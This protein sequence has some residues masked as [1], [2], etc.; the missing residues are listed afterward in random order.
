MQTEERFMAPRGWRLHHVAETSST[1]DLAR[2]SGKE[3]APERTLFVADHQTSG[4]G[5]L[6]RGWLEP[7]GGS[8]LFSILFR[9]HPSQSFLLTM[10]C[11]V[12][13]CEAIEKVSGVRVEIKW[14]NDLMAGGRKL[15]GVLTEAVWQ[16]GNGFIVVGMGI[17]VNFDPSSVPGIPDNATSLLLESGRRFSR[18]GLLHEILLHMDLLLGLNP[19]DLEREVRSRWASRLWRRR[20][21]VVASDG[22]QTFEGVFEDVAEDGALLLRLD[23]GS[24]MPLRVGDLRI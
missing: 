6:G 1:N 9:R 15:A 8:L 19:V 12:A 23:D 24:L 22:G 14:P 13:A 2:E 7:P 10:L 17:N 3:E 4:R 5:R 18:P 21:R 16:P 11:S 20:Q